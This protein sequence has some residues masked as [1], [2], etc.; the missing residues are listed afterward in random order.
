MGVFAI[1]LP[2]LSWIGPI[3]LS[4]CLSAKGPYTYRTSAISFHLCTPCRHLTVVLHYTIHTTSV[5]LSAFWGPPRTA[6]V[7]CACSPSSLPF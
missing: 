7:I 1:I 6:D 3:R 2:F 4:V 5:T